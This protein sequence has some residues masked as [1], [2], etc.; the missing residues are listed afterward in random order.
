MNG[1]EVCICNDD[2][3]K[4]YQN[5]MD[6]QMSALAVTSEVSTL[7]PFYASLPDANL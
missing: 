1:W 7:Q 2:M 4:E 6:D 5:L 3:I